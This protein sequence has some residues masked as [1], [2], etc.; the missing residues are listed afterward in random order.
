MPNK[1]MSAGPY[2]ND[3]PRLM[4]QP[5]NWF[6]GHTPNWPKDDDERKTLVRIT[7][8]IECDGRG[9]SQKDAERICKGIERVAT[10]RSKTRT[11]SAIV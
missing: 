5:K 3:L 6:V 2:R 8:K 10:G 4:S 11:V 9:L 7:V 1:I